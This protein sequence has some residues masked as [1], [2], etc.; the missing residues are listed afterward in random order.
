MA[1]TDSLVWSRQKARGRTPSRR[2]PRSRGDG[3]GDRSRLAKAAKDEKKPG[4]EKEPKPNRKTR[5]RPPSRPRGEARVELVKPTDML[6][7]STTRQDG[8]A[9]YRLEVQ[10]EQQGA[11]ID[12]VSSSRYDAESEEM[13]SLARKRPLRSGPA[14]DQHWPPSLAMTLNQGNGGR[15][16]GPEGA[17]RR[18]TR[19]LRR[20][21]LEAEDSLDSVLWEVVKDEHGRI[22]RPVS[23]TDRPP[24]APVAGQAVV[25]RTQGR[26]PA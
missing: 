23:G 19:L 5:P 20:A 24:D 18:K 7:G 3:E 26:R 21:A 10:L 15:R 11:G 17:P 14:P 2:Q 22:V 13:G 25:F 1:A 6:L 16:R 4:P 8:P 12:S 9:G